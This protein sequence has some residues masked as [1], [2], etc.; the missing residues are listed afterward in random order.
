M[1]NAV[2]LALLRRADCTLPALQLT[3]SPRRVE[4]RKRVILHFHVTARQGRHA[5]PV[6]DAVIAIGG[7][8][9]HVNHL[10]RASITVR[11]PRSGRIRVRVTA[12]GYLPSTATITAI[13]KP[14]VSDARG[15]HGKGH[16]S[17][18][19]ADGD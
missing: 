1:A 18:G 3:A 2:D 13:S 15:A 11:F 4:A 6:N 5:N 12:I 14:A 17:D 8:R 9:L 19:R 16:D 10:G 7:D